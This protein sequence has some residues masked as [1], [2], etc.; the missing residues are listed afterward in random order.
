MHFFNVA[1]VTPQTA[2][3]LLNASD[4]SVVTASATGSVTK[5]TIALAAAWAPDS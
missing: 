4:C 1:L 3:P 2:V 5:A